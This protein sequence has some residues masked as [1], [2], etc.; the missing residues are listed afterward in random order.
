MHNARG[1]LETVLTRREW[2]RV[3]VRPRSTRNPTTP[4]ATNPVED[5]ISLGKTLEGGESLGHT[6][7]RCIQGESQQNPSFLIS[8]TTPDTDF[9]LADSPN[10]FLPI[11]LPD[12]AIDFT[13]LL[14]ILHLAEHGAEF[15]PAG[16]VFLVD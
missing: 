12:T 3:L 15:P 4:P 14:K 2:C 1:L 5:L 16:C 9:T 7:H 6:S 11:L 13:T 8:E 10:S